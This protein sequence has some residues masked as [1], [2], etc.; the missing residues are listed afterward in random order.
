MKE[1]LG[2][3]KVYWSTHLV[4]FVKGSW[5]RP[6]D[7]P[8]LSRLGVSLFKIA[9]RDKDSQSVVQVVE[10]YAS[11]SSKRIFEFLK[12]DAHP[13]TDFGVPDFRSHEFDEFFKF[14]FGSRK[15]CDG[16]CHVCRHCDKW[17]SAFQEAYA[18]K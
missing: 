5:V 13:E 2:I 9:G 6:E 18:N 14:F 15:G 12:P 3:C 1:S 8:A 17:A 16:M 7:L 11:L 10:T 4:D